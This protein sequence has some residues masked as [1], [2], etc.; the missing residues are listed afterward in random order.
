MTATTQERRGLGDRLLTTIERWGNKLPEP[1]TLFVIL[2]LL[3]GAVS[4]A[5]ALADVSVTV[6]GTEDGPIEIRGLFTGEGM[7]WFTS[8]LGTNYVEFPPLKTVITILLAVGIAEKTGMLAAVVRKT[9]GS[10]PRW[11]LPYVVGLVGV[12]GSVMAD[13]AFVVIP[14]L[15]ALVFRAAGRHPVAG[16][17]GGFAAVGAGY[18][19]ALVPTSLDALFAGITTGVMEALPGIET[20]PVNPISNYYFNI[21]AALLLGIVCGFIIDRILEPRMEKQGVTREQVQEGEDGAGGAGEATPDERSARSGRRSE[22]VEAE[23]PDDLEPGE[24]ISAELSAKEEQGL[25]RSLAAAGILTAILLVAVLVPASPWRNEEGGFLPSSP[26]LDSIVFIVF[27]YFA[28]MG[29]VYGAVVGTVTGM[30]DV[31]RMMGSALNDMMSFLVL[32]FILGQF[33]ALFSWTGIGSWIAVRGASGLEAT[34]MT[35]FPAVIGF[36]L[37]AS[38]LNLFIVSGSSMWTI[39]GAVFVPMFALIGLEPAFTQAAFRVGDSATQIITPLN[40]YMIVILG[41]LRRY[42]PDAGLGTVIS[43]L[44]VFVIPFWLSWAGLVAVWYFLDLPLG[45]GN[46]IFLP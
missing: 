45:P 35:G 43:R 24:E 19:T 32:A 9:F 8:N 42:E 11:M 28:T 31:V 7:A 16:L 12:T 4:T 34:G 44:I 3:T 39:M 5:M 38:C 29:V 14:P 13:S 6:P 41:L 37:L 15:A 46:G 27:A 40:P 20:S 33:I 25:W 26:L 36:I 17:L 22:A 30:N 1:F 21:V 2:F 10:A 18:S 23:D